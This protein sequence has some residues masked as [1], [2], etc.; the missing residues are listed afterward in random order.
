[1][2]IGLLFLVLMVAGCGRGSPATQGNETRSSAEAKPKPPLKVV[3]TNEPE[4][5]EIV[6]ALTAD[7]KRLAEYRK[8]HKITFKLTVE[9]VRKV[10]ENEY[11]V[12]GT[13][14]P[15]NVRATF[16]QSPNFEV[17]RNVAALAPGNKVTFWGEIA[18]FKPATPRAEVTVLSGAIVKT[19]E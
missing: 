5:E 9:S 3:W 19:E 4:F 17:N 7:P 16:L 12:T 14:G 1:M 18:A 8:T 15:V 6:K 11:Q 2:R 10:R 13:A